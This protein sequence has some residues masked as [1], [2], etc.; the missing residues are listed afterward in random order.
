VLVRRIAPVLLA[1]AFGLTAPGAGAAPAR[2]R[3]IVASPGRGQVIHSNVAVLRVRVVRGAQLRATL[4]GVRVGG[5]FGPRRRGTRALRA[6]ISQ[7]LRR[8]PNLLKVIVKSAGGRHAHRVAV[9]FR[10]A[11]AAPLLGAG[12]DEVAAVGG[13]IELDGQVG[14]RGVAA[15]THWTLVDAP[16]AGVE[17]AGKA[18]ILTSPA[19]LDADFRPRFPGRYTLRLVDRAGGVV[20][21]DETVV[22]VQPRGKLVPIDTMIASA[23]ERDKAGIRVGARTFLLKEAELR[24]GGPSWR[25]QVVVLNRKDLGFVSNR[26]YGDLGSLRADLASI[27]SEDLVIA[28]R[29]SRSPGCAVA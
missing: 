20:T 11:R 23:A 9:R 29:P 24:P 5:E 4:N 1:I 28:G 8:G 10:V 12:R 21:G 7:G 2:D 26:Q 13:T 17:D 27:G 25:L 19:G 3:G 14:S 16:Q 22:D 15:G 18:A 6:S